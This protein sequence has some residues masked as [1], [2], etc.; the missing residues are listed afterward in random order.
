MIEHP[1]K[2]DSPGPA[3]FKQ[4]RV[5]RNGRIFSI[6]KFRTMS[7]DAEAKKKE[8]LAQ[9]EMSSNLMF[10]IK[11]DPRVTRVGSILRKTSLDELPQFINVLKGE[12]SLVGTR[13][14]TL[15]EVEL[16][17]YAQWRRISITPGMTG[18]WQVSGRSSIK[19]FDK[20][21]ALDVEYIDRW[22]L[23]L[24]LKII[25]KTVLAVLVRKS[26]Y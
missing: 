4:K 22:S 17:D 21:V 3:L 24:D 12:M 10:K 20:I 11:K 5:G 19:D 25:M 7:T 1:F 13:P 15:D 2:L 9:N 16:Y 26:A 23:W 18:I 6:Y 14:P 8:I